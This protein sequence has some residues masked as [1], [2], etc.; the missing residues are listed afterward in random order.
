MLPLLPADFPTFHLS[1]TT[2]RLQRAGVPAPAAQR[3]SPRKNPQRSRVRRGCARQP[4]EVAAGASGLLET[5]SQQHPEAAERNRQQQRQRDQKRRLLNLAKNNLA[6]DLKHEASEVWLS[7][8]GM[9][10]LA[11]NN[12]AS[13]KVFIYQPVQSSTAGGSVHLEKNNALAGSAMG[14]YNATPMLTN[15]QIDTI[16]RLHFVEKWTCRKIAQASAHRPAHGGQVSGQAGAAPAASRHAPANWIRSSQR[17][18][19]GLQQDPSVTGRRHLPTATRSWASLAATRLSKI[20]CKPCGRKRKPGA[21]IVR[22]EPAPA[23]ASRSTGGT[24]ALSTTTATR[25][26]SMPSAWSSVTAGCVSGVHPQPEFETFVRCHIHAFE[27]LGGVARELWF[28]NWPPPSPN[29]MATWCASIRASWPSP[30]NTASFRVPAMWRRPGKKEK[31]NAR[32]ATCARTS[33]RCARFTDL[34]DVNARRVS[35]SSRVANQRRHRETGQTPDDRFQPEC[36]APVAGHHAR[37][38]ATPPRR[39]STKISV[40]ISTAIATVCRRATSAAGS[41]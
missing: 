3:L 2:K 8:P 11:K 20:T 12:L 23:N 34:H 9:K 1:S 19:N 22:M 29:T 4:E 18:R 14:F 41:P 25:A 7:G 21:P 33:G 32:S 38:I 16:H 6:L 10:D 26:S 28:D 37:I 36:P 27:A 39:W 17:S 24:S 15:E 40:C 13:A 5:I 31:W 30:A 35:G